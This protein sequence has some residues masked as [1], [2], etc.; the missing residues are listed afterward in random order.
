MTAGIN[1]AGSSCSK[2]LLLPVV[3]WMLLELQGSVY[4]SREK[5]EQRSGKREMGEIPVVEG[6]C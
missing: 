3:R 5:Q 1:G 6:S 2:Q 4:M